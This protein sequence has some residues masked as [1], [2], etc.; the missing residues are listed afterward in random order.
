MSS[1][2]H[3]TETWQ[4]RAACRGPAARFFFPP[5]R[6]ER[7]DEKVDREERAKAICAECAVRADCLDYA[8]RIREPHG[9]WG[10][11]TEVERRDLLQ[12]PHA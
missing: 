9:I 10:G 8:L 1:T 5:T 7:K 3:V 4:L 12:R 2:Q 11:L 6:S